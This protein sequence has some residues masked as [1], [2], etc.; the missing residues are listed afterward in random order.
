MPVD[1]LHSPCRGGVTS[2]WMA[3]L[4]AAMRSCPVAA[5]LV[6]AGGQR[7]CPVA[8]SRSACGDVRC[9]PGSTPGGCSSYSTARC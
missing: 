8:A 1:G 2:L 6:P 3:A 7:F 9:C 4:A 5:M